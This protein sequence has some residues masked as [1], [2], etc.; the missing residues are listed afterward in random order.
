MV[1]N[2]Q[3]KQAIINAIKGITDEPLPEGEQPPKPTPEDQLRLVIIYYLSVPD[4]AISKEDMNQFTSMLKEAGANVAA[5]EYVK[6]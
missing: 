2:V 3:P 6:R 4:N 5:L 1:F